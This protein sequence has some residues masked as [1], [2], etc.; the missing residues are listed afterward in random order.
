MVAVTA[1]RPELRSR[2]HP[3]G[4]D[5]EAQVVH[6]REREWAIT[7]ADV[8]HGRTTLSFRGLATPPVIARVEELLGER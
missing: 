2:L 5:I 8:L 6:A 3:G 1:S 4:P 7:P